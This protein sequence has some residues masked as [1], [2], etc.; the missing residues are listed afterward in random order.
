MLNIEPEVMYGAGSG[1]GWGKFVLFYFRVRI[2]LKVKNCG[3]GAIK[4]IYTFYDVRVSRVLG[5]EG[6][7][8]GVRVGAEEDRYRASR[9][10]VV[11]HVHVEGVVDDRDAR[12]RV[13]LEG[14]PAVDD[15]RRRW[16]G[17]E[18]QLDVSTPISI[19][20]PAESNSLGL[21]EFGSLSKA[22]CEDRNNYFL[23]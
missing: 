3:G 10:G 7:S 16:E 15:G 11:V 19:D 2:L 9:D 5:G 20:S 18:Q 21:L 8:R 17:L 1:S 23:E 14:G 6:D 12:A 4:G 13:A 22:F